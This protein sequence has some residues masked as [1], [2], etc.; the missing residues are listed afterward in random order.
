MRASL[1]A[2]LLKVGKRPATWLIAVAWLVLSLLFGYLFPYLSYRG[3]PTGPAAGAG[4]GQA[5]AEQVLAEALPANLVPTAIQGFPVFAG[6]LALLLGALSAGSEYGWGTWKTILAQGPGRL[7]VLAGKLAAL[8]LVLGL[9]VL[10]T[11]AVA[12][13][14]SWLIAAVESQPL[15]W[16]PLAEL[17][18]GLAAGWLVVGM[19]GWAGMFLGILVRG[20]SLAIG[21]GLV[22][23]LAVENLVRG[24]ASLLA[25]I[26]VLQRFMPGTNAGSVAA[27]V[28]VPVQGA[29]GGTLGVTTTVDGT[30]ATLVL[31]AYLVAF[32]A[33]AAVL[34]QRRDVT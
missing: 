26:E 1:T 18:Q 8:G 14:A 22:W 24:F 7:A 31:A 17:A 29:P 5:S 16:P 34:L 10:A 2:E 20:T 13:P 6:A 32:T 3:A 12:A 11:F 9:V 25:A 15:R 23:T 19:W 30:R 28:G 21:L 33:A 27:A 4:A